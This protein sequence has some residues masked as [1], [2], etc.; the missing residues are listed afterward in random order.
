MSE[1]WGRAG[2]ASSVPP[3]QLVGGGNWRRSLR[4]GMLERLFCISSLIAS[5]DAG[6]KVLGLYSVVDSSLAL[7]VFAFIEIASVLCALDRT[8]RTLRVTVHIVK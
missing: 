8:R 6:L 3:G 1:A 7:H 5:S 4:A 2:F